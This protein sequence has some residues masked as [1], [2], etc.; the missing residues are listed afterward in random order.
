MTV[1]VEI[2][3]RRKRNMLRVGIGTAGL[4]YGKRSVIHGRLRSNPRMKMRLAHR[5]SS[6]H[7][8]G[9]ALSG[10]IRNAVSD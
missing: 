1:Q 5:Q 6:R 9:Q 7:A 4:S 10:A 8:H 3:V 2:G